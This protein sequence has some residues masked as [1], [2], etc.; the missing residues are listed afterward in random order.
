MASEENLSGVEQ[1]LDTPQLAIALESDEF[2]LFLSPVPVAIAVSDMN[3]SPN[4]CVTPTSSSN[5]SPARPTADIVGASGS[6]FPGQALTPSADGRAL[7]QAVAEERDYVGFSP[8][9][10]RESR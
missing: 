7:G 6:A 4:G 5:A 3:S 2:K 9:R 10:V 1:L 8:C